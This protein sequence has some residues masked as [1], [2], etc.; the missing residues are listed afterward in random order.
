MILDYIQ[1]ENGDFS[2]SINNF[3]LINYLL[4]EICVQFVLEEQVLYVEYIWAS[5][6]LEVEQKN[7]Y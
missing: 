2:N 3:S 6:K 5:I 7:E 1:V 4:L